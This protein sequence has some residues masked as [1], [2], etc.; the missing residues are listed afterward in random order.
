MGQIGCCLQWKI[1][2]NNFVYA[3]A[4]PPVLEPSVSL[5]A[6]SSATL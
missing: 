3:A 2:L 4:I 6:I 1:V 5:F